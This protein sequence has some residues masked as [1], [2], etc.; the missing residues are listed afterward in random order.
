MRLGERGR[1]LQVSVI[2][3]ITYSVL[4]L[5]CGTD[6]DTFPTSIWEPFDSKMDWELAKWFIKEGIGQGSIDRFLQITDVSKFHHR[7][8]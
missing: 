5:S 6:D 2:F 3:L 8:L 7:A 4:T 1:N